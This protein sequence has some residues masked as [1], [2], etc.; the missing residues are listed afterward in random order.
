[1]GKLSYESSDMKR[2]AEIHVYQIPFEM[3]Y[4]K[5]YMKIYMKFCMDW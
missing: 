4:T 5:S 3:S 1:M 2:I